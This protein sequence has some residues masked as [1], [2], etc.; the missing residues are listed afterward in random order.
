MSKYTLL[1]GPAAEAIDWVMVRLPDG[2]DAECECAKLTA[3]IPHYD[4]SVHSYKTESCT[5]LPKGATY[6]G[7]RYGD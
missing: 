1:T 5:V 7:G 3:S 4:R 6:N 2:A